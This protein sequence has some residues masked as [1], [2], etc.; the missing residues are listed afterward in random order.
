LNRWTF[1]W[2]NERKRK[3]KRTDEEEKK[4]RKERKKKGRRIKRSEA[5][6]FGKTI[7]MI[8]KYIANDQEEAAE[9]RGEPKE[10]EK[11]RISKRTSESELLWPNH[12]TEG[13]Q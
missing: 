12:R 2:N 3:A 4:R 10:W 9:A 6:K 1:R 11:E 13:L 5:K 8:I 7:H